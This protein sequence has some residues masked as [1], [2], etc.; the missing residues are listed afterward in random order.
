MGAD[1]GVEACETGY[2]AGGAGAC[3]EV[4]VLVGGKTLGSCE[5]EEEGEEEERGRHVFKCG[6]K[7][8]NIWFG[9]TFYLIPR[10]Y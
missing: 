4:G 9:L 3:V 8:L 5:D 10:K 6:G 7:N 2:S 1:V